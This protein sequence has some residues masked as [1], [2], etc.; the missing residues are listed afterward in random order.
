MRGQRWLRLNSVHA[1]L[2]SASGIC[3]P[4]GSK[5]LSLLPNSAVFGKPLPDTRYSLGN[6]RCSRIRYF[7]FYARSPELRYSDAYARSRIDQ[8]FFHDYLLCPFPPPLPPP[9]AWPCGSWVWV[10]FLSP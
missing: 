4:I 6:A 2:I 7:S 8:I 5:N 10:W 1:S 3:G 9:Y